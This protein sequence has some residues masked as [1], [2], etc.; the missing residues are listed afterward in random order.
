MSTALI[1]GTASGLG[2]ELVKIFSKNGWD[3]LATCRNENDF[4]RESLSDKVTVLSL[5]VSDQ[6]SIET[7]SSVLDDRPI[8]V[9]INCAGVYD[10]KTNS[11]DG[12]KVISTSPEIT[13][14]FQVNSIAPRLLAEMLI[15]NLKRGTERLVITISSGMGIYSEMDEYHAEH[16]PYSASKA[17]VNYAMI[18]LTKQHPDIK[19]VLI[20]P[21]WMK[22]K[23][24]GKDAPLEPSFSAQ[25]IFELILDHGER[26]PNGKL[27]DYKGHGMNLRNNTGYDSER[28]QFPVG[29]NVFAIRDGKLLLGRRKNTA[30]DGEWGLPG[31]HLEEGERMLEC[32]ARELLEETGMTAKTFRF[33][34]ADN[35]WR[36]QKY[37]FVH[38]GFVA[39][40]VAGEPQ[41]LEPDRCSEWRW[42]APGSLPVPLFFGHE[43][44]IRAFFENKIFVE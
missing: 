28:P 34:I 2:L 22:T 15:P 37:H 18:A 21:G 16:W 36:D 39:E 6:E 8:D 31:G 38:F 17:A 1:T 30:G 44:V 27:V 13:K 32:A 19:S 14:I 29:V 4:P 33:A 41:V 24:G 26:L 40:N 25:K 35:D 7:I 9:L 5:D 12:D 43:E 23:I 3:V 42:F 10:T 20:S 11:V